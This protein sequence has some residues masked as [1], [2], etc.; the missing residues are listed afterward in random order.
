MFASRRGR[1]LAEILDLPDTLDA[2]SAVFERDHAGFYRLR[3]I[4][5]SDL[6]RAVTF[7]YEK[8]FAL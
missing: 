3:Y 6:Y 5:C 1:P 8:Y 2:P 7:R 4:L